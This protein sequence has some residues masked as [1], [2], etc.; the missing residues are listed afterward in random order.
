MHEQIQDVIT[1]HQA[2]NFKP[3]APNMF[4]T[5][6]IARLNWGL[7]EWPRSA[8][9]MKMDEVRGTGYLASP[10]RNHP[11]T[12]GFCI[13]SRNKTC[14]KMSLVEVV[15]DV[16]SIIVIFGPSPNSRFSGQIFGMEGL[17][18]LFT[19][20]HIAIPPST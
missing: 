20:C 7:E 14:Q 10:V 19:A 18:H 5:T 9:C 3:H 6:G 11:M 15:C 13:D 16:S 8:R 12:W 1:V 2:Q 17:M 4:P